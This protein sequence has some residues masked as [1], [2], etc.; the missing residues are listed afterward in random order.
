MSTPGFVCAALGLLLTLLAGAANAQVTYYWDTNGATPGAGGPT[1]SGNWEGMNWTTNSTG[2]S[3]TVNWVEG[4]FPLFSAGTDATGSYTITANSGHTIAGM[5]VANGSGIVTVNG[6]GVLSIAS[7]M[8]GFIGTN[9][10]INAVLGGT[11]GFQSAAG[12][13]V[14]LYGHN[15]FSGGCNLN[16]GSTYINNNNA[17]GTGAITPILGGASPT[18]SALYFNGG[19]PITLANNFTINTA[20]AGII[21]PLQTNTPLTL[22]GNWS[23]TQDLYL[24]AAPANAD[25]STNVYLNG[26][27]SGNNGVFYSANNVKTYFVPATNNTYTGKTTIGASGGNATFLTVTNFNSFN[28]GTPPLA[29]SSLGYPTTDP[30]IDCG[31]ITLGNAC[32]FDYVGPGETTDRGF[33]NINT[34]SGGM[35]FYA[36]GAGPLVIS[37]NITAVNS[38][39]ARTLTLQGSSTALNTISGT[40][41]DG[42]GGGV[43]SVV[44]DGTGTWVLSGNNTFSGFL[45]VQNTPGTGTSTLILNSVQSYT[46][47]TAISPGSTLK[48]GIDDA[49]PYGAGNGN[50]TVTGSGAT[51]TLD[52]NGHNINVNGLGLGAAGATAAVVDNTSG[53]GTYTIT[54]G[55][56]NPA[57]TTYGVFNNTVGTLQVIKTGTGNMTMKGTTGNFAGGV[58]L[59]QGYLWLE[60]D[61]NLG[62][63]NGPLTFN[64]GGLRNNN[65]ACSVGANRTIYVDYGGGT[66]WPAYGKFVTLSARITGP[67]T[68]YSRN[69]GSGAGFILANPANDWQGGLNIGSGEGGSGGAAVIIR[70]GANNVIPHG[71]NAGDVNVSG[72]GAKLDMNGY[73]T[74]INGLSGDVNGQIDNT[75]ASTA[76]TLTVGDND[77]SGTLSG[78]IIKNSGSGST[79]AIIK[80]GSGTLTTTAANTYSGN[81]T[82]SAG[83]LA[84]SASGTIAN[85]PVISIAGGATFDVSALFT[86]LTLG[87]SQTLNA[88]GTSGSSATIATAA[89]DGLALGASS[90][91][92]FTAYDGATVPLT[93]AGGDS[94]V[95]G[96]GNPVTVTTTTRLSGGSYKLVQ[97]GAGNTTAVTGT[98]AGSVTVNG[99]G[100]VAGGIASLRITG[101]E[102]YLDVQNLAPVTQM[103][104]S[105]AGGG[106]LSINY[107][108]GAA[109]QF[110]LLQTNKVAAPLRNWTRLKTNSTSPG[111]FTVTPGSDPAEFYRVKSE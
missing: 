71:I 66:L 30:V 93:I 78:T 25:V 1:P 76:S 83:T 14:S 33:N 64:G 101:G 17:L 52:L 35:W 61:A 50:V 53:T 3:A 86:A 107:S 67:G 41:S 99:S 21:M 68:L 74:A 18:Y 109:S 11:G 54:V 95:I 91:L 48:I 2:S 51:A 96:P 15:T 4:S 5:K 102:L 90:P 79:L 37:G 13:N 24:R 111:S 85:S 60:S 31:N 36:D 98:P 108:G 6:P 80:I 94:L 44:K 16:G 12:N 47:T 105:S 92:N 8:Q 29:S 59:N 7:G 72:W 34:P 42:T 97:I 73:S 56:N 110:V 70:L 65:S 84:L 82:I 43:I 9:L 58:T 23:L 63:G 27:I 103:S 20:N 49:L 38:V 87:A 19:A 89:G 10:T 46:S 88:G 55:N 69:D 75:A 39:V 77:G 57:V 40:I 28:G 26:V 32:G 81:T 62:T 106:N 22:K 104:I 100:M 45:L